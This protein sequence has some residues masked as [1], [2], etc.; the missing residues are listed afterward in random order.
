M[1]L[2]LQL[3]MV[4]NMGFP[5]GRSDHF[6]ALEMLNCSMKYF[7]LQDAKL[8][9]LITKL[10]VFNI[11]IK[12]ISDLMNKLSHGKQKDKQADFTEDE[13]MRAHI[14]HIHKNN[15]T[16]FE[17]LIKG[18]PD[19][20]P[21]EDVS[22]SGSITLEEHLQKSLKNIDMNQIKIDVLSEEQIDV[23]IQ[24]LDAE[25]KM[26]SADMNEH[27]MKINNVYEDRGQMSENTRQII[28]QASD[29][30]DSI[31]RKIGR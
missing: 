13:T 3:L 14:T 17:D 20:I 29:F 16:I 30:I 4:I 8:N 26:Y 15:P 24:G 21:E 9:D 27:L 2:R 23:I 28:K 11:E 1:L 6:P 19:Y 5:I 10:S 22:S 25:L 18:F 7:D 12:V 31:N